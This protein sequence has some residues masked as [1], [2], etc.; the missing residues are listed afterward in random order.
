MG[1]KNEKKAQQPSRGSLQDTRLANPEATTHD[2]PKV[3]ASNMDQQTLQ[4]VGMLPQ[5]SPTQ[6]SGL[7]T[8]R[9]AAFDQLS[10]L[11]HQALASTTLNSPPVERDGP[12]PWPETAFQP[13]TDL[14][15]PST[16]YP[17]PSVPLP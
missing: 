5:V 12:A 16:A 14:G 4:D 1:Q 2:Q 6:T 8:M 10:S 7:V 15:S 13:K 9:E 3:E 17:S 11:T